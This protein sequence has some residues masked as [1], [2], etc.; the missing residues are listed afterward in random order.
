MRYFG[1]YHDV[2]AYEGAVEVPTPVGQ[3]CIW[4]QEA[5]EAGDDGMV[6]ANGPVAHHECMVRQA[7]GGV[8]HILG[9]CICCGGTEDP[10]PPD[11]TLRESARA[12]VKL[13]HERG[14]G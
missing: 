1:A 4:C 7:I 14:Y 9:R 8:N 5:I 3:V 12:A 2:P 11:M 13:F 10:D 6:Y